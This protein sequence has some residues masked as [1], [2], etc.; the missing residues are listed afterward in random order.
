MFFHRLRSLTRL[1]AVRRTLL[2]LGLILVALPF[3]GCGAEHSEE[4]AGWHC[5]MH[6]TYTSDKPGDCPICGMKLVPIAKS[7]SPAPKA[8]AGSGER[9]GSRGIG[10]SWGSN[11]GAG[12]D[13]PR[14]PAHIPRLPP[15]D[16]SLRRGPARAPN[17]GAAPR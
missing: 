7:E 1:V 13:L 5:P 10:T 15:R 11:P 14:T 9:R 12:L 17:Q 6:P 4:S 3:V 8:E 16:G 2:V